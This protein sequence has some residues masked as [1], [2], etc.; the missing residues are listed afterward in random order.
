MGK[1]SI[2]IREIRYRFDDSEP[3]KNDGLGMMHIYILAQCFGD[4]PH[5]VDGWYHKVFPAG[6]TADDKDVVNSVAQYLTEFDR[7]AP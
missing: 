2:V 3:G 5:T 4:C 1:A 7:G 6:S